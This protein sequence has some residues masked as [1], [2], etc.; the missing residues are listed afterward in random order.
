MRELVR[1]RGCR[2]IDIDEINTARGVGSAG[3]PISPEEWSGSFATARAQLAE[4]FAAGASVAYDGHCFARAERDKLRAIARAAGAAVTLIFVDS[5]ESLV[6]ERWQA[7][8]RTPQ[9][10]DIPDALFTRAVGLMEAPAPAKGALR[11]D[12]TMPVAAWVAALP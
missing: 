7:N 9:R 10:H 1:Q 4:A 11:Y 2:A 12:G 5:P 6:R 3:A 8:R